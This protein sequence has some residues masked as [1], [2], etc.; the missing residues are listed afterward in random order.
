[1]RRR[2]ARAAR[3]G[4]ADRESIPDRAG[5]R[6]RAIGRTV[7][8][9]ATRRRSTRGPSLA[10][11]T[12]VDRYP[13]GKRFDAMVRGL[14]AL[15]QLTTDT[16][17]V[18]RDHASALF[19]VSM[20]VARSPIRVAP[21]RGARPAVRR[22]PVRDQA[23]EPIADVFDED[24]HFA[25]VVQLPGIEPAAVTWQVREDTAVVIR[26]QAAGRTYGRTIDLGGRVDAATATT[27]HENGILELRLWK[28]R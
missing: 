10:R 2:N 27:R 24:D 22:H 25:V 21:E 13:L 9:I 20:G 16:A 14:G 1:M 28:Q 17:R 4:C 23:R 3:R 5:T 15:L 26:A 8:R 18:E 7:R 12:A 19:G 6:S 11:A